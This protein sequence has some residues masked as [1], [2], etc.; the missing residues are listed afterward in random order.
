MSYGVVHH[1][2]GGTKDQYEASVAAVHPAD[3]SLPDGQVFHAAGP[4][5]GGWTIVAIHESEGSWARFR[6]ETLMP[7]MSAGIA[8]G[9][10]APPQETT[11]PVEALHTA[12]VPV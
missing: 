11:F 12:N 9:F 10:S 3:G 1:F 6:D 4:S 8:G 7:K 5:D 2:P